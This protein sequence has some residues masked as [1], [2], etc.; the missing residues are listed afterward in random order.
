MMAG[1]FL[2]IIYNAVIFSP[3]GVIAETSFLLSNIIAYYRHY[4]KNK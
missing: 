3:M 2:I 4:I 1:T